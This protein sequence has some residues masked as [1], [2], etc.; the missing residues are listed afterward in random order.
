MP[1]KKIRGYNRCRQE[2]KQ[3][4]DKELAKTIRALRA[5]EYHMYTYER[6]CYEALEDEAVERLVERF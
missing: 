1:V 3:M 5:E 2:A 6:A 4:S